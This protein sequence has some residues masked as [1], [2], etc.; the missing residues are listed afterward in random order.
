MSPP[1]PAPPSEGPAEIAILVSYEGDGMPSTE[2]LRLRQ[3]LERRIEESRHGEVT[4]A[5]AGQGLLELYI[6][7]DD[8]AKARPAVDAIID[9]LGLADRTVVEVHAREPS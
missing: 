3:E 6:A 8:V 2:D 7:T 4:D 1:L 5:G 9:A